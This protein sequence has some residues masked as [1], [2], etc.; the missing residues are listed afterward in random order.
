VVFDVSK[1]R[2]SLISIFKKCKK[3]HSRARETGC[4]LNAYKGRVAKEKSGRELLFQN[5][6]MNI[7]RNVGNLPP[8]NMAS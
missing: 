6:D 2:Y 5:S 8:T 4:I 3:K 1:E 7:I